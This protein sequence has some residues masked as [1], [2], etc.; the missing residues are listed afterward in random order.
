MGKKF[1][2]IF[3]LWQRIKYNLWWWFKATE[4][5]K[6]ECDILMYGSSFMKNGKRIN[7]NKLFIN[8]KQHANN[9]KNNR[10]I[11]RV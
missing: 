8:I 4:Q 10:N 3:T 1:K 7:P 11:N 2:S 5:D 9:K 6:L